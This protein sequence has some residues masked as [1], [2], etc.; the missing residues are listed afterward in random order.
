MPKVMKRKTGATKANSMAEAP[1]SPRVNFR[2]FERQVFIAVL[3]VTLLHA[4][5]SCSKA[6]RA[7]MKVNLRG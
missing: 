4:T 7:V 6:R 1:L 3:P 5:G 2:K